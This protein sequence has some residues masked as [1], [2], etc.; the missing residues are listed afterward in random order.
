MEKIREDE[1]KNKLKNLEIMQDNLKF[2]MREIEKKRDEEEDFLNNSIHDWNKM[3]YELCS[4]TDTHMIKLLN[5][6]REL[7]DIFKKD[8]IDRYEDSISKAK[9]KYI[10]VNNK[11][12]GLYHKK[13]EL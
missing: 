3:R 4:K 7:I 2:E 12:D 11:I 9:K 8:S 5:R 10:S 1:I 13:A 6:Q